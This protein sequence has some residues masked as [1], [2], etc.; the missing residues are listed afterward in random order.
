MVDPHTG[1]PDT[2]VIFVVI[3]SVER[4]S[5]SLLFKVAL[6]VTIAWRVVWRVS[7]ARV[8]SVPVVR[9]GAERRSSGDSFCVTHAAFACHFPA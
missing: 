3:T 1:S 5:G 2:T 7:S 9:G 4:D 8:G 6:S